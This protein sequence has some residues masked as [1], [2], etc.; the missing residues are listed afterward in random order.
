M[1]ALIVVIV[2]LF[3]LFFGYKLGPFTR[4]GLL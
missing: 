2:F 1:E 4:F 3:F